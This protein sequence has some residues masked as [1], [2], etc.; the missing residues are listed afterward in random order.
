M[1]TALVAQESKFDPTVVSGQGGG[2]MQVIPKYSE[3]TAD[4]LLIPEI[5]IREGAR[6]LTEHILHY[7]YMD[8]LERWSF[9]L[10]TYNAGAGHIADARRIAMDHN[11]DPNK[12]ADVSPSLLKKMNQS[13]MNKLSRIC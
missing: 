7:S 11:R 2:I 1:F 10:A 12:W 6:I 9:A 5:N 3:L 8:S 13:I 4:S